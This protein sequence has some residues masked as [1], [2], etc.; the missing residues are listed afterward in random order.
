MTG[1]RAARF[2]AGEREE[3]RLAFELAASRLPT[4][5]RSFWHRWEETHSPHPEFLV[6]AENGTAVLRL[7]RLIS[8][9]YRADGMTGPHRVTYAA[10]RTITG[11]LMGTGLL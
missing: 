8:G 10:G 7:T 9:D 6:Y 2:T 11:A 5:F 1:S 4:L 3:F